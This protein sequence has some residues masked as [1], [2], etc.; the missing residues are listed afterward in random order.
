M[1]REQSRWNRGG[2]LLYQ[3]MEGCDQVGFL[4]AMVTM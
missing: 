3:E 4:F 2:K 1:R